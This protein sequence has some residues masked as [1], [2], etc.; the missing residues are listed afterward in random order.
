MGNE[1]I[2]ATFWF[3]DVQGKLLMFYKKV[4]NYI[5]GLVMFSSIINCSVFGIRTAEELDYDVITK[6]G[7]IEIREYKPYI[8]AQASMEGDYQVIRSNLF[9]TLAGYI[10]GK[11]KSNESIAMTAPVIMDDQNKSDNEKI[12]M[13]APVLLNESKDQVWTMSFSMPSKYTMETLPK[14]LDP[15]VKLV[16]V[17]KKKVAVIRYSGSFDNVNKRQKY[18]DQLQSWLENQ[19]KYKKVGSIEFAGYDPP[20]TLPFLRRN[21]VMVEIE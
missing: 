1:K 11:N 3:M 17:S 18:K 9:R 15:N 4:L 2:L 8:S 13:T 10:F 19:S 20:F 5:L 14:P 7:T 21:E 16:E 6:E 12:A